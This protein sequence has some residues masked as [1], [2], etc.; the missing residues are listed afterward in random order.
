MWMNIV[1][2]ILDLLFPQ[3]ESVKNIEQ[4]SSEAFLL[5]AHPP[6][7][8]PSKDI[9]SLFHYKDPL[10]QRALWELKYHGNTIV[11]KLMAEL[12]YDEILE[13]LADSR[14]FLNFSD[15]LLIPLPSSQQR[16]KERGWNQTEM[17]AN[18][19]QK[20][21]INHL[22]SVRKDILIKKVHTKAQT[23][24][25]RSK[26]MENLKGC[27]EVVKPHEVKMRNIILLDDVTTTG[28]TLHEAAY[29]LKKSGAL[30][31]IAFTI[32]H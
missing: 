12:L 26:R 13:Y 31:I 15:P 19:L 10:V 29:T 8:E 23:R 25:S 28:S 9:I 7:E 2:F 5:Q 14:L 18:A 16:L 24:L 6:R 4:L 17:L 30:K 1:L 20:K 32:A 22:F 3:S 11:A 27:F 21:D